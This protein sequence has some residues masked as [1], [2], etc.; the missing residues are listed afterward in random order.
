MAASVAV[1]SPTQAQTNSACYDATEETPEKYGPTDINAVTGNGGLSVGLNKAA[2]VT[3]FKW[4]SPSFYDQ[5]K[6]RTTDRGEPRFGALPNEGAFLGLA[7][8]G[9]SGWDFDWLREWRTDQRFADD[10]TD[11]VVTTHR[12]PT[13]GLTVKVRDLVPDMDV[14]FRNVTVTRSRRS[15]IRMTRLISFANF[16][17]VISKTPQEPDEDWCSEN[18]ND[19]GAAYASKADVI[20]HERSGTDASTGEE[21]TVALGM[22]FLGGSDAF[23]VGVDT[24]GTA[25]EDGVSAYDDAEDGRLSGL[26]E[27]PGQADAAL[28]KNL[29]LRGSRSVS[30]T[31]GLAAAPNRGLVIDYLG[32]AGSQGF[33][34]VRD[35]KARLWREWLRPADLPRDAPR[36]VT[37]LAKRSLITLRHVTDRRFPLVMASISTQPPYGLDWIRDGSYINRALDLAGHSDIVAAH[38]R[39]YGELQATAANPPPGQ[40]ATPA[41]N[42]AQNYYADGVAGGPVPYQ[43]DQTGFG[44]WTLW[45]HYVMTSD[46]SYLLQARVYEAI[47]RA[48]H[49][50][51]D[52]YPIGCIDPTNNLQCAAPEGDNEVSTQTLVGAQAVW[53]GLDSASRAARVRGG[54]AALENAEKWETRR[55]ELGVAI[56][57][58]FFDEGCSCYTQDYRTGGALLWPVGYLDNN[59]AIAG[60]QADVNYRHMEG[61]F[62]GEVTQGGYESK[63]LLGN[64]YAWAGTSELAKV[65]R[66]LEWVANVPTTNGT[67]LLGEAW[68]RYPDGNGP[69]TTMVA[70]PH[71]TNHA[72]F[73]LAAL[74]A[75]GR[76]SYSFD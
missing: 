33:D 37:R 43:I 44:I 27:A 34:R 50:L 11:E 20:V 73:Y 53:L 58:Q 66:G 7:W 59:E 71:A 75:Y 31:V 2:T 10:D 18:D 15:P 67:G 46:E 32:E 55:D 13:L 24:Y 57:E 23:H 38:N 14:L 28:S 62:S 49:Y 74:K 69:V 56:H 30:T 5:I 48:A 64:A 6:Y 25:N 21:S 65:R 29:S 9:R 72:M 61:I 40:P 41:G 54:D 36:S 76:T 8:R 51:S 17:P 47:Q 60:R 12:K 68:M 16:N 4:P 1:A 52:P 35:R 3:V 63:M 45:D 42:W 22:K 70:Q 19:S 26:A 39:R